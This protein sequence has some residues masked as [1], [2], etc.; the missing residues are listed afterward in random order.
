MKRGLGG[1]SDHPAGLADKR[2]RRVFGLHVHVKPSSRGGASARP[3][4]L[5]S[6]LLCRGG[7]GSGYSFPEAIVTYL[8]ARR[9][10]SSH[11]DYRSGYL[12]P[13]LNAGT[14]GR[15]RPHMGLARSAIGWRKWGRLVFEPNHFRSLGIE[16]MQRKI[17]VCNAELQDR[18][19]MADVGRT[20]IDVLR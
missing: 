6:H 14:Q 7:D 10:Y 17:L 3:T 12:S 8:L 18:A 20:F 13:F 2:S 16:P 9:G 15:K 11:N 19:G 1:T 5:S 4:V